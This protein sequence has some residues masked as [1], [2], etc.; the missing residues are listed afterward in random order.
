MTTIAIAIVGHNEAHRLPAALE[1]V[2]WADELIYVDCQ[3]SDESAE[4]AGRFTDKVVS[5]PN[6]A[7]IVEKRIFSFA[8]VTTE[9]VFYMDPDEVLSPELG[10]EIRRVIAANPRENGFTLPRRNH[11]FGR[12]LRHGQQYPDMQLRLF[13]NGEA[14]FPD[15][16]LHERLQ[17]DGLIG[18][19]REPMDHYTSATVHDSLAKLEFYTSILAEDMARRGHVPTVRMAL[20]YMLVKPLWRFVRRYVLARGFLDG[21]P[22]FL[23]AAIGCMEFQMRFIKLWQYSTDLAAR[24][25]SGKDA[26]TP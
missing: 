7:T 15:V 3:S 19:L 12:W 21:W 13:R 1:S 26:P 14:H 18:G 11:F 4:I 8:H 2:R 5:H 10:E 24:H 22:G 25:P 20:A 23:Q 9:W 16:V 6:E 17:V